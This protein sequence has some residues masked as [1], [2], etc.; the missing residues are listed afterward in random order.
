VLSL[1][2]FAP[3]LL[4]Q[5]PPGTPVFEAEGHGVVRP[6]FEM[7]HA[8]GFAMREADA[9]GLAEFVTLSAYS[10]VRRVERWNVTANGV[11]FFVGYVPTLHQ[12]SAVTWADMDG[13]GAADL[14]CAEVSP[15]GAVIEVFH[16]GPAGPVSPGVVI[17]FDAAASVPR[18]SFVTVADVN[19]DGR[20]DVGVVC[21]QAPLQ[22]EVGRLTWLVSMGPS[23]YQTVSSG[24]FA[25]PVVAHLGP[26]ALADLVEW[27]PQSLAMGFVEGAGTGQFPSPAVMHPASGRPFV[28]DLDGD[29]QRDVIAGRYLYRRDAGGGTSL[30]DS[31]TADA[32]TSVDVDHDGV[33]DLVSV[34]SGRIQ[35]A[36]GSGAFG[37]QPFAK[38]PVGSIDDRYRASGDFASG[39]FGM[40][41]VSDATGDGWSD[42]IGSAAPSK[43]RV[44]YAVRGRPGGT[45]P[46]LLRMATGRNPV[47]VGLAN[48]VNDGSLDLVVLTRAARRLEVRPGHGNGDFG[49]AELVPLPAGGRKFVLADLN[50]DGQSDV[51]VACD[52]SESLRVFAGTPAGLG[53]PLD[54]IASEALTDVQAADIDEDGHMDL[55]AATA[56][57][58]FVGWR[59]DGGL[60]FTATDWSAAP[61]ESDGRFRLADMDGDG[62]VDL[63]TERASATITELL[64]LR[65]DGAGH[66]GPGLPSRFGVHPRTAFEPADLLGDGRTFV[67]YATADSG[68]VNYS[69]LRAYSHS[70]GS[71]Q[72]IPRHCDQG[73]PCDD[74]TVGYEVAPGPEQMAIADVTG[75]GIPD[76][77]VLSGVTSVLTVVP[78]LGGGLFGTPIAHVAGA[79]PT[80][81]ALGDLNG[82]GRPDV[83][84][85]DGASDELIFMSNLSGATAGLAPGASPSAL[86][87]RIASAPNA[88]I[89]QLQLHLPSADD[90][91][92]ELFD[93]TGRR[94]VRQRI[95]AGSAGE[96]I[97]TLDGARIPNSG[98]YFAR[99][100]QGELR[101][102]AR[103]T[104]FH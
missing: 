2:T 44:L 84:V 75:D 71:L 53:V 76:A 91:Q 89:V 70:A 26:D 73:D 83:V 104:R 21:A 85:A 17:A 78:G 66:F 103:F 94:L 90:A 16:H 77:L 8:T 11:P 38:Y 98:V 14:V 43:G 86:R 96:R 20:P 10:T 60:G 23:A 100:S 41:A 57:G 64:Q 46:R 34:R 81:F 51:A 15:S 99:V 27:D 12:V 80:S 87:I 88:R 33:M 37:F 93:V 31:V 47:Q 59:G 67:A 72:D 92:L 35:V 48:V 9:G 42:V 79:Q 24:H 82:D 6:W 61:Y 39:P 13:D 97:L 25:R 40:S 68:F 54:L 19:A 63:V 74:R 29:G 52:T 55:L 30:V 5:S 65:G 101:A 56:R 32:T 36:R 3:R 18:A 45:F 95:E 58:G 7:S 49:S 1:T 69:Y 28:T 50:G 4:A 102:S 62:H 22:S